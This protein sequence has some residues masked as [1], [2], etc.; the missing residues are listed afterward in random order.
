MRLYIEKSLKI[1][2]DIYFDFYICEFATHFHHFVHKQQII[3]W[4]LEKK[5]LKI[6][7]KPMDVFHFDRKQS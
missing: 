6:N 4:K 3:F 2:Y 7:E 5:E 1:T